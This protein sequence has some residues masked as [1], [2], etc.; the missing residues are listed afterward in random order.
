MSVCERHRHRQKADA[1][2]SSPD[3]ES[4]GDDEQARPPND[5]PE[6]RDTQTESE[7]TSYLPVLFSFVLMR[8]P[9]KPKPEAD[10]DLHVSSRLPADNDQRKRLRALRHVRADDLH[11]PLAG[12][13]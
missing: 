10:S 11:A 5:Q 6:C 8:T 1:E 12:D 3:A 9:H 2:H 13:R 4:V 7:L